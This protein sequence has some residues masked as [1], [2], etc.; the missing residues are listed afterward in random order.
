[1]TLNITNTCFML[2]IRKVANRYRLNGYKNEGHAECFQRLQSFKTLLKYVYLKVEEKVHM[3][4]Y[5]RTDHKL[6]VIWLKGLQKHPIGMN[7]FI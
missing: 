4:Q 3:P 5:R 1:M 2:F 7:D 6:F